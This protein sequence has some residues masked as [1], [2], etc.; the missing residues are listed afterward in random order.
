MGNNFRENLRTELNYHGV[1]I[2]ELSAK[3]GIPVA[4][5]D[6]YLGARATVPSVDAAVKIAQALKVSVE[7]L[8]IGERENENKIQNKSSK[9]ALEILH[10]LQTLNSE[11]CKT[12]LKLIKLF[13]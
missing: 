10:W 11:Q 12:I 4:T 9:E 1:T 2:K 6:C 7:Y 8:V 5:L 13:K 3:T